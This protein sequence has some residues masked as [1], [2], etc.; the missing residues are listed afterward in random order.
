MTVLPQWKSVLSGLVLVFALQATHALAERFQ[1]IPDSDSEIVFVSKAPLE[2]FK[3]KTNQV[4][5]WV[6][7]DLSNLHGAVDIEVQV[8]LAS[9]DTGKKK[10]NQHMRDNHLETKKYPVATFTAGQ[11]VQALTHSLTPGSSTQIGLVGLLHL[12]GVEKE[13]SVNLELE[14]TDAGF[15]NISGEFPVL[16]SDH[17]IERPKFLVMKLA[18]EQKV[19]IN[20]SARPQS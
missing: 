2:T 19:Q 17:A 13:Y 6:V 3:G 14:M 8:Q 1:I 5:G 20:L 18:D 16:L 4:S 9:F 15:L 11:V 12:H 10:R 7:A